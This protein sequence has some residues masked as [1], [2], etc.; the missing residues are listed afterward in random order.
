MDMENCFG[1]SN[2]LDMKGTLEM[3]DFMGE[4]PN[5]M[6]DHKLLVVLTMMTVLMKVL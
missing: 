2:K 6:E 5:I 4:E 1:I 3:V